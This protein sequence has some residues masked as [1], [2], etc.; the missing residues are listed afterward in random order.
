MPDYKHYVRVD[1][2]NLII[3]AFC[4]AFEQPQ[5]GDILYRE[6]DERHFNPMLFTAWGEPKY[7]YV[8]G[9]M[10]ER[11]AEELVPPP[12]PPDPDD[13]LANA[14]TAATTL[15]ELKSALLGKFGKAKVA[16]KSKEV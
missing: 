15:E 9:E 8:S 14:I 7:R 1:D 3:K 16:G 10:V 6:T 11:L 5:A 2:N 13:E 12:L 4:N